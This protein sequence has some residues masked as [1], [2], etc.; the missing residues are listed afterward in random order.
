MNSSCLSSDR[1]DYRYIFSLQNRTN[2]GLLWLSLLLFSLLP[3]DRLWCVSVSGGV[4]SLYCSHAQPYHLWKACIKHTFLCVQCEV[5]PHFWRLWSN[6]FS[7]L[8]MFHLLVLLSAFFFFFN[9]FSLKIWPLVSLCHTF[10]GA[11]FNK[12]LLIKN[13]T[14][15]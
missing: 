1:R 3:Y 11:A 4:S 7:A 9:L 10:S 5:F 13:K 6:G 12:L 8:V 15:L 14:K 2:V